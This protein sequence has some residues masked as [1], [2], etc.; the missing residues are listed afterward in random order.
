MWISPSGN[1]YFGCN[2]LKQ[3]IS[4]HYARQVIVRSSATRPQLD[5]TLGEMN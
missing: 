4:R 1:I 5:R 2:T 3:H